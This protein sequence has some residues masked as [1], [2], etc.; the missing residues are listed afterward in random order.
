MASKDEARPADA[1]HLL[2]RA[3][4]SPVEVSTRY[5]LALQVVQRRQVGGRPRWR[6]ACNRAGLPRLKRIEPLLQLF[7]PSFQ[8]FSNA[9]VF[10]FINPM[11]NR[12]L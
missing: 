7:P 10:H 11:L 12:G 4:W 2:V 9:R 5:G 3:L 1:Q 6:T 8:R